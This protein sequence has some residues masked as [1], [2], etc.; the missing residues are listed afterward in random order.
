[1][2]LLFST[3]SIESIRKNFHFCLQSIDSIAFLWFWTSSEQFRWPT[4]SFPVSSYCIFLQL[5]VLLCCD[6]Q[7]LE[8][9]INFEK[10]NLYHSS[11]QNHPI[12]FNPKA[13]VLTRV[14]KAVS[15]SI[16][17]WC[18]HLISFKDLSYL[19]AGFLIAY[20]CFPLRDISPA[21][22]SVFNVPRFNCGVQHLALI[23]VC[24]LSDSVQAITGALFC[25]L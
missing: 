18:Y 25:Q 24:N 15:T 23:A 21:A 22:S 10:H 13:R 9:Q 12:I 17:F 16:L 11:Y 6:L 7:C 19:L 1:M 4:I 3:P 2:W 8:H 5:S 20:P 14:S